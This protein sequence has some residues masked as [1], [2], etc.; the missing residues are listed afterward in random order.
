[1]YADC[2]NAYAD[3]VYNIPKVHPS[4]KA[5]LDR[6]RDGVACETAI[7]GGRDLSGYQPTTTATATPSVTN[8][9][10]PVTGTDSSAPLISA[11]LFLVFGGSALVLMARKR[12]RGAHR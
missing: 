9:A 5:D 6:D 2:S 1:M 3:K 11:A 4:Y 7:D 10:L 12:Y 8:T